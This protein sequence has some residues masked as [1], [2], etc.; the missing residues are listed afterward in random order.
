MFRNLFGEAKPKNF[1]EL[2]EAMDEL[3]MAPS[4]CFATI[5][6]AQDEPIDAFNGWTAEIIDND[7]NTLNTLGWSSRDDLEKDL[8]TMGIDFTVAG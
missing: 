1:D 2:S 3:G 6:E 7:G 5:E 4:E 8:N